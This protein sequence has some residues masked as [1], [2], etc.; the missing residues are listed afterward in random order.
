[1]LPLKKLLLLVLRPMLTPADVA[2]WFVV[3]LASAWGWPLTHSL[4]VVPSLV[5][6]HASQLVASVWS[7][8]PMADTSRL[9]PLLARAMPLVAAPPKLMTAWFVIDANWWIEKIVQFV[10]VMTCAE[11]VRHCVLAA[12]RVRQG[13]LRLGSGATH[14]GRLLAVAWLTPLPLPDRSP[15]DVTRPL[16]SK[17]R[18]WSALSHSTQPPSWV[19]WNSICLPTTGIFSS[20]LLGCTSMTGTGRPT[21][22]VGACVRPGR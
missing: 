21:T 9:V 7:I 16:A 17:L 8:T 1:M 20:T 19:G 5:A 11:F 2:T 3:G 14:T 12:S 18:P 15:H 13:F 4:V 10:D 6:I 22:P